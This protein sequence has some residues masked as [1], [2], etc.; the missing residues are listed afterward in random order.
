LLRLCAPIPNALQYKASEFI[1]GSTSSTGY[2]NPN[3]VSSPSNSEKLGF[4]GAVAIG[5]GQG[6]VYAFFGVARPAI[7]TTGTYQISNPNSARFK[8][9]MAMNQYLDSLLLR[10]ATDDAG[11]VSTSNPCSPSLPNPSGTVEWCKVQRITSPLGTSSDGS[12][13]S[14]LAEITGYTPT[15]NEYPREEN[16]A[17]ASPSLSATSAD[18]TTYSNV[19][20]VRIFKQNSLLQGSTSSYT[21]NSST[22]GANAISVSAVHRYANGFNTGSS[23]TLDFDDYTAS[24]PLYSSVRFGSGGIAGGSIYSSAY[25]D[26]VIGVPGYKSRK[27]LANGGA[28]DVV[29]NG[30]AMVYFAN[31]GQLL[32]SRPGDVADF[33]PF[34]VLDQSYG[35]ESD[36]RFNQAVA[37]GD[38]ISGDG[39]PDLAV[40]LS[41]GSSNSIQLFKGGPNPNAG[42]TRIQFTP[43][44][45]PVTL[46]SDNTAGIRLIP[47]GH[48][49]AGSSLAYFATGTT[50]SYL[51]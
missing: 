1:T 2:D 12:F 30:A 9:G 21:G 25:T 29:D 50:A 19:G 23:S 18:G 3:D 8:L 16:L 32:K 14:V 51:I 28:V 10:S 46:D 36:A 48:V 42:A 26:V 27:T 4:P 24:R 7:P 31:G 47:L 40:R 20:K 22:T 17:I 13:G 33:A 15:T 45:S 43:Y 41:Q 38:A 6:N 49:K 39:F 37:I 5:D 11:T 34:H 44:G 35:Q